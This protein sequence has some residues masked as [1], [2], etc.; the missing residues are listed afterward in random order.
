MKRLVIAVLVVFG[1]FALACGWFD[2]EEARETA[3]VDYEEGIPFDFDIDADELCPAGGEHDCD[4]DAQPAPEDI[5]LIPIDI[6]TDIDIVEATG[7]DELRDV[8]QRMRSLE[9]TGID[10]E[11]EDNDLTFDLPAVDIFVG[12]PG[13]EE[14]DDPD[15]VHLTTIPTI[16]AGQNESG[17]APVREDAREPSSE[18][19]KELEFDLMAEALPVVREGQDFPP[20]GSAEM[21]LTINIRIVANPTDEL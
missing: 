1:L 15:S 10:Y 5:E 18:L 13:T 2:E 17:T 12:P 8:T 19:F 11:A 20:S 14:S 9:I 6:H 4:D 16:D 21:E 7:N 3:T